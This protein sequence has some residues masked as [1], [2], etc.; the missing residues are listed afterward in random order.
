MAV[1]FYIP[2]Q[3]V[4]LRKSKEKEKQI[5]KMRELQWKLITIV[6]LEALRRYIETTSSEYSK[7]SKSKN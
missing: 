5:L 4:L 3:E 6:V 2:D 7:I 1:A